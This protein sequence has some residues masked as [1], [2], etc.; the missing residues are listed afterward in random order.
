MSRP[1]VGTT[2]AARLTDEARFDIRQPD[3]VAPAVGAD[4]DNAHLTREMGASS[5]SFVYLAAAFCSGGLGAAVSI[6]AF[7]FPSSLT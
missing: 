7:H 3:I 1:H 4:L 6:R 5:R 2:P